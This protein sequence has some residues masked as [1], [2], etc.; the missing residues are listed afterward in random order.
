MYTE[1][2]TPR[3]LQWKP[4]L[5]LVSLS[6][7]VSDGEGGTIVRDFEVPTPIAAIVVAIGDRSECKRS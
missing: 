5:G 7:S 6:I 2:K 1:L 3:K 4:H